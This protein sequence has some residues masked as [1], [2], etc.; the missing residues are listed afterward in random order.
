M[1]KKATAAEK[2]YRVAKVI[3]LLANGVQRP[4]I[5]EYARKEWDIS[6]SSTD[7]LIKA[8]KDEIKEAIN[9]QRDDFVS[10]KIYQLEDILMKAAKRENHSAMVGAIR[11]QCEIAQVMK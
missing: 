7:N 6:R 2:N 9:E 1:G 4:D 11:L 8:A 3:R 10:R 5:L